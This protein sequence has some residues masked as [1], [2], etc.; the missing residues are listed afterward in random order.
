MIDGSEDL[1]AFGTRSR[2]RVVRLEVL[3]EFADHPG[4][5]LSQYG[6]SGVE[7]TWARR[8]VVL[9]RRDLV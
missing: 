5:S 2:F 9:A 8:Y 4:M 6:H 1:V 7:N 3:F